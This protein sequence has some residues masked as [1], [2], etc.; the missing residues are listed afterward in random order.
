MAWRPKLRALP[1]EPRPRTV[2]SEYDELDELRLMSGAP[3]VVAAEYDELDYLL[4]ISDDRWPE[5][6]PGPPRRESRR[7]KLLRQRRPR[8]YRYH[9]LC[10][11]AAALCCALLWALRAD[12]MFYANLY[13]NRALP[14]G[15]VR[16]TEL[17]RE[18]E[19]RLA[20]HEGLVDPRSHHVERFKAPS[21]RQQQTHQRTEQQSQMQQQPACFDIWQLDFPHETELWNGHS[22]KWKKQWGQCDQFKQQCRKTCAVCVATDESA[23]THA[24]RSSSGSLQSDTLCAERTAAAAA[25]AVTAAAAA[26]PSP[27]SPPAPLSTARREAAAARLR[28]RRAYV[29]GESKS[30][31]GAPLPGVAQC[32]A[33]R[34]HAAATSASGLSFGEAQR[35]GYARDARQYM[36]VTY[37]SQPIIMG[38]GESVQY[39]Q[40]VLLPRPHSAIGIAHY[41]LELR[42]PADTANAAAHGLVLK[43][44]T[45]MPLQPRQPRQRPTDRTVCAAQ[46]ALVAGERGDG[47]VVA[48][49]HP[50]ALLPPP[51]DRWDATGVFSLT[52][53]I[54]PI[55]QSPFFP[56]LT[57]KFFFLVHLVRAAEGVMHEASLRCTCENAQIGSAR[58][59]PHGCVYP[60]TGGRTAPGE[61]RLLLRVGWILADSGKASQLFHA[62]GAGFFFG[63]GRRE[64]SGGEHIRALTPFW[65]P[66]LPGH[67]ESVPPCLA[68]AAHSEFEW[69]GDVCTGRRAACAAWSSEWRLPTRGYTLPVAALPLGS[70]STSHLSISRARDASRDADETHG[71]GSRRVRLCGGEWADGGQA[72]TTMH[73]C[74]L[75]EGRS[76]EMRASAMEGGVNLQVHARF[77]ETRE[78]IGIVAGFLVWVHFLEQETSLPRL[79][80]F[81]L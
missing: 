3:S 14:M 67:T 47:S 72:A 76:S 7:Q 34:T 13:I 23:A 56:Y 1:G 78:S 51:E 73:G 19:V 81:G 24:S 39:A 45:L 53:P 61:F 77:A 22:C 43:Q 40:P 64:T 54:P 20:K 10:L 36:N 68:D 52:R 42:A 26:P 63:K 5:P 29:R 25:A 38:L 70:L 59:C 69:S 57:L 71:R 31:A 66:I 41:T 55:C 65:M 50:F 44:F 15:H 6:V 12:L 74:T 30:S 60:S 33:P 18:R 80:L 27:P 11:V 79:G 9:M 49:V 28:T 32:G 8:E 48:F 75:F 2:V 16:E 35:L 21:E 4:P 37:I 17:V 58:C 62:G 46:P